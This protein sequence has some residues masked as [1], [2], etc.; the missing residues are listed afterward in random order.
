MK[1]ESKSSVEH[2][3]TSQDDTRIQDGMKVVYYIRSCRSIRE[4]TGARIPDEHF[5]LILQD[6]RHSPSPENML[7]VRLVIH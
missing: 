6:A 7:T 5:K 3:S 4:S 2:V 1:P